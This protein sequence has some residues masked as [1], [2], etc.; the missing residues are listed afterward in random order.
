MSQMKV[1]DLPPTLARPHYF[2]AL[3]SVVV[4]V[5]LPMPAA[6]LRIHF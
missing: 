4:P 3:P 5:K 1:D 6:P 2:F